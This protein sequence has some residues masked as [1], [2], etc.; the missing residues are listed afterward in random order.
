RRQEEEK[1]RQEEEKCHQLFRLTVTRRD[2][3]YEW[4]KDR[5]ETRIED[6]CLWFLQHE[7]FQEWLKQESDP[8]LVSADPGCGKS[9]LAKYLVDE[10]LPRSDSTICYFFFKD[11]DQNT[12]RQALCALLHQ[13]FTQK[14]CLI[15]HAVVEH[16][17]DGMGLINSTR[18]LWN[19]LQNAITDPQAGSIIIV[20]DA[21]DECAESD[22]ADLMHN[23]ESH[24]R[25]D[26][27][28]K[29]K[30]LLTCRPYEAI[31]SKF[32]N[33]QSAFPKIHIPGEEGSEAIGREINH[34]IQHQLNQLS[35]TKNLSPE[36]TAYLKTRLQDTAHRTYLWVYLIFDYLKRENFK[37]TLP[38]VQSLLI[39]PQ[40]VNEA[41]EKILDR[42]P[43]TVAEMNVALNIDISSLTLDLEREEDFKSR[44]RSWCGLF[45]SIHH[46]KIYFLHQT[47]REF[48]QGSSSLATIPAKP[49]RWQHSISYREAHAVLADICRAYV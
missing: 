21:L 22:F 38:A 39:L 1:R 49:K 27:S 4:Y 26:Q 42:Q 13:L 44:L 23:V 18:T 14:P 32:Y 24:F 7:Y 46:D 11:Q 34:V 47:A 30:Y 25:N 2:A 9:V 8:L 45:I 31:L 29:V 19:I 36:I 40:N 35:R 33:L 20:L 41:Y 3:T 6:T 48:L 5:V 37:K 43:L 16:R 15:K 17:K 28:G 12:V 10:V